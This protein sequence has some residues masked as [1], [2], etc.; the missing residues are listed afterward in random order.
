M[1]V[2]R[3]FLA[4]SI[5]LLF[6]ASSMPPPNEKPLEVPKDD[7]PGLADNMLDEGVSRE[8]LRSARLAPLQLPPIL[9]LSNGEPR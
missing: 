5:L 2:S 1:A 6:V 4:L 7:L 8:P 3:S 9:S